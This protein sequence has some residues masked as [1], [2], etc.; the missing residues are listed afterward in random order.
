MACGTVR[1]GVPMIKSSFPA[2][3]EDE[4]VCSRHCL[5]AQHPQLKAKAWMCVFSILGCLNMSAS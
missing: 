5:A 3:P 1:Q 2:E 4:L